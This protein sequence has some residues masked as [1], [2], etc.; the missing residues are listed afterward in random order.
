MILTLTLACVLFGAGC[1][2]IQVQPK[3]V[4]NKNIPSPAPTA[5]ATVAVPNLP[6]NMLIRNVSYPDGR[7][8]SFALTKLPYEKYRFGL[9][10][11]PTAPKS[12]AEWRDKLGAAMV[13]NGSYFSEDMGPSGYY[14]LDGKTYG[15]WPSAERQHE[16]TSYTGMVRIRD[17]RLSLIHLVDDPQPEP[18]GTDQ[19]LLTFPT[20]VANGEALVES[21]TQKYARRTAMATAADGTTYVIITQSGALSLREFSDW[22]ANQPEKFRIAVNLDGGPSTG[23]SLVSGALTFEEASA[24]VP[25]VV[26]A[27]VR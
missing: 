7:S 9:V 12:V 1:L 23:M 20:L 25:N 2:D 21:D 26:A 18:D 15:K 16:K 27:F 22:L 5:T 6:S 10:N 24:P 11:D 4:T 8:I 17:G 3:A 13:I 14:R 19:V